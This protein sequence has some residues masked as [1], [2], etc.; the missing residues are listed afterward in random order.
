MPPV[1]RRAP[2]D[3]SESGSVSS[4]PAQRRRATGGSG[5]EPTP[6]RMTRGVPPLR[7]KKT[8]DPDLGVDLV[9]VR[10]DPPRPLVAQRVPVD[11]APARLGPVTQ[12]GIVAERPIFE[13]RV[14]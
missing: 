8:V 2:R 9:Q 6:V 5:G 1:R 7:L 14:E 3:K 4:A 10:P 11:E 12:R 13:P